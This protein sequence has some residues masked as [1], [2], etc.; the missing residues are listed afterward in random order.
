MA[1]EWCTEQKKIF[2]NFSARLQ[3]VPPV[4]AEKCISTKRDLICEDQINRSGNAGLYS[5][6]KLIEDGFFIS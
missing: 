6:S 5:S 1:S 2:F 3:Q 4:I